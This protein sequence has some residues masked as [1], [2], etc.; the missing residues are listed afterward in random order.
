M[1]ITAQGHIHRLSP[2]K[3][4]VIL[5]MIYTSWLVVEPTPSEKYARHIGN[6]PQSS[7]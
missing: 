4:W 7:G 3:K 6:R 1:T 5:L 2:Q